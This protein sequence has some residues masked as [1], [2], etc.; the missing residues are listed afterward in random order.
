MGE[1]YN[2]VVDAWSQCTDRVAENMM[3]SISGN[4][5]GFVLMMKIRKAKQ[6]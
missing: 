5:E 4:S 1:K 3:K 6:K 2:K